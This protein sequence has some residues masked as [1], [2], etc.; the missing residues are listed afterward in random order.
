MPPRADARVAGLVL[1][2]GSSSRLGRPK[3]LL[4]YGSGTLL[5]V[6]LAN[7]RACAFD[8]LVCAVGAHADA[9]R[10]A[11]DLGGVEVVENRLHGEGCASSIAAGMRALD[12]R[13]DVLVL[14][15]GD[16]PGVTAE[17]VRALLTGRDEAPIAVCRYE[18]GLGHPLAFSRAMFAAL[19]SLHGDRAVWKLLD[20][21][22]DAVAEVPISRPLPPDVDTWADYAALPA[23]GVGAP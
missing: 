17:V 22:A 8:Q 20:R 21:H 23:P 6:T 10:A 16:Q 15:L 1:A 18:D 9:V 5:D 7:A 12:P 19:S 14:M 4:R 13:C 11:V 2:A 3:Q